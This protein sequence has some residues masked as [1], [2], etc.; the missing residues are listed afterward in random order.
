[1]T[2]LLQTARQGATYAGLWEAA[3]LQWWWRKDQH[4]DVEA[5]TFWLNERQP[6]AATI[7]TDWGAYVG[8]DILRVDPGSNELLDL[9]WP[10]AMERIAE[11]ADGTIEMLIDEADSTLAV[12]AGRAGFVATDHTDVT[13]WMDA[14]R[15]PSVAPPPNGYR[16]VSRDQAG[17]R[18]HH[19]I[20]RNG[21]AVEQ[22]LAEC[23]L[24][25]A[26]L[27]LAVYDTDGEVAAYGLFWADPHTGVG[28]VEPMRTEEP[29]Q[30]RGLGRAVL[31]AGL[32]RLAAAGC[33][34]FKVSYLPDND[35]ARHLY[36]G[37]GFTDASTSRT[38]TRG[39]HH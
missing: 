8:L 28:L 5:A 38:W 13:A 26:D 14:G 24:Y 10:R 17:D 12:A 27:D 21:D 15:R 34:R 6:V 31:T 37:A 1:M 35:A 23:S 32:D 25:R 39:R 36:L 29:F 2:D 16:L 3:D 11:L 20:A 33:E 18:P 19:M 9:V 4:Q 30:Q 22:R 7:C